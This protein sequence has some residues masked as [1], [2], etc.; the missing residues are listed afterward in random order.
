MIDLVIAGVVRCDAVF[1]V[2][3]AL[4]F[5]RN[6]THLSAVS[7]YTDI[8]HRNVECIPRRQLRVRFDWRRLLGEND[9]GENQQECDGT[10]EHRGITYS[11]RPCAGS[12]NRQC[13]SF[14]SHGITALVGAFIRGS[15]A[16]CGLP[17]GGSLVRV[18]TAL[19][20][21]VPPRELL[22]TV[23]VLTFPCDKLM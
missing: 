17:S 1:R 11:C 23:P 12:S 10:N 15:R 22:F 6:V 2:N 7:G 5:R 16:F 9:L 13:M 14:K 18:G 8:L 19:V 20:W 4:H 21:F 3:F